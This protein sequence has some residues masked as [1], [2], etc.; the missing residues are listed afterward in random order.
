MLAEI[1]GKRL[2]EVGKDGTV[3]RA[4]PQIDSRTCYAYG[5]QMMV[6]GEEVKVI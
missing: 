1:V 4:R 6:D 5:K 2:R 3:S